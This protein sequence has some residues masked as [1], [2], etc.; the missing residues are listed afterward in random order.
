MLNLAPKPAPIGGSENHVV[1]PPVKWPGVEALV[2]LLGRE[3]E[4][5]APQ[6]RLLIIESFL[7]ISMSLFCFALS[8]YDSRWLFR[9]SAHEI[10][11]SKF[12]LIF[13]GGGES[14]K[15]SH[16]PARPPRKLQSFLHRLYRLTFR[17]RC[18][19]CPERINI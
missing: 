3:K 14:K 8:A 13:G 7:A 6:L 4:D 1:T 17:S 19:S 15:A 18:S 11:P 10:D 2:A 9:L 16:P 5:D 12:G